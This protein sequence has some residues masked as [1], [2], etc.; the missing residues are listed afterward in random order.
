MDSVTEEIIDKATL[1]V[2][3]FG[4][5]SFKAT[6]VHVITWAGPIIDSWYY[7]WWN[8]YYYGGIQQSTAKDHVSML[9]GIL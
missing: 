7:S 4:D 1:D 9:Y 6:D 8:Y 3:E 5:S 2:K